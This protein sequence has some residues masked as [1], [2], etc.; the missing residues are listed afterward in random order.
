[1]DADGQH[2]PED[3]HGLVEVTNVSD[4][5]K[6]VDIVIGN[7]MSNTGP[8]PLARHVTNRIMSWIISGMCHQD[9]PDTQCGYRLIR[10][11]V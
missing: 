2:R 5:E 10:V 3:I 9:I 1:M 11:S 8:M 4:G 7:R 6:P